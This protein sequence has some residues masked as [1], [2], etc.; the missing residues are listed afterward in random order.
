MKFTKG[1]LLLALIAGLVS[2]FGVMPAMASQDEDTGLA[3]DMDSAII[4]GRPAALEISA[5]TDAGRLWV[6]YNK[7]NGTRTS[8]SA[9]GTQDTVYTS[10]TVMGVPTAEMRIMEV[11]DGDSV[12]RAFPNPIEAFTGFVGFSGE[13]NPHALPPDAGETCPIADS[14][15]S[16][17][18]ET[19]DTATVKL[20]FT[21]TGNYADTM[22]I[23]VSFPDTDPT[24]AWRSGLF[25]TE[26]QL[27]L[28]RFFVTLNQDSK[29][30]RGFGGRVADTGGVDTE[31]SIPTFRLAEDAETVIFLRIASAPNATARD[32]LIITVMSFPDSGLEYDTRHVRIRDDKGYRGDN[33]TVYGQGSSED[34]VSMWV[35]V[36]TAIVRVNKID[37]VFAPD[38][39]SR[40]FG[41][42][43]SDHRHDT[44]PGAR[45]SYWLT[46]DND[47][48]RRADSLTLVDFL[49]P[50]VDLYIGADRYSGLDTY[51]A[52]GIGV[53][54]R[55]GHA[56]WNWNDQGGAVPQDTLAIVEFAPR[57]D[58]R[59]FYAQNIPFAGHAA[60][61]VVETVA[62]IRVRWPPTPPT[63]PF[64][65]LQ[66]D[67]IDAGLHSGSSALDATGSIYA[68]TGLIM[69]TTGT[70]DSGDAGRIL[71]QVVIR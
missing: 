70:S 1:F 13:T 37:T 43:S 58:S 22:Y 44:V 53:D 21:N 14:L 34:S 7:T 51:Y 12:Y 39:F 71:F 40:Q 11:A 24:L 10:D 6:G 5:E 56:R 62:A 25:A 54:T 19:Y 16:L 46:Y 57:S 41:A 48:N 27:I 18:I 8:A 17:I 31:A 55:M 2:V 23:R 26:K 47:G 68:N 38:S 42:S 59:T 35:L 63:N 3:T 4:N 32:S 67:Q 33:D 45:L 64:T 30:Q 61:S 65:S 49:N 52:N 15:V 50:N 60:D 29:A 20:Q 28:N 36:A 9:T 69:N 66:K